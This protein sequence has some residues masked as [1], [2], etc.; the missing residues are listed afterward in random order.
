MKKPV[1]AQA[2][3]DAA[4]AL[5]GSGYVMNEDRGGALAFI[6]QLRVVADGFAKGLASDPPDL[7]LADK[8]CDMAEMADLLY[9]WV[10]QASAFESAAKKFRKELRRSKQCR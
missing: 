7:G 6:D 2:L 4:N 10:R 1:T 5:L 9:P 3:L 8:L